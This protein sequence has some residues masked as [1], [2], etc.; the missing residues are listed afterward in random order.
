MA[1]ARAHMELHA[2]VPLT[3]T[4]SREGRGDDAAVT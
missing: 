4:L 2:T 1:D 3:L